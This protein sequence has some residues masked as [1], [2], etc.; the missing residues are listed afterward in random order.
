M[1][2][3][4]E[5]TEIE[6]CSEKAC[7]ACPFRISNHGRK[8]PENYYSKG[9]RRRLWNGLRTG[10]APGM[11]CHPTDPQNQPV[12]ERVVTRECAGAMLLLAREWHTLSTTLEAGGSIADYRR[13]RTLPLTQ[14]G[15]GAMVE[16]IMFGGTALDGRPNPG[17]TTYAEDGDVGLG[18]S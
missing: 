14:D 6:A 7:A 16:R 8:H 18:L 9:N 10:D 11:T 5:R 15:I 2:T 17:Q 1:A 3:K 12:A 4:T 13:G